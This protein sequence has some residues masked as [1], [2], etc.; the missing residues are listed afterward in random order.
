LVPFSASR[1]KIS[2]SNLK[3]LR[4]ERKEFLKNTISHG[5]IKKLFNL[6]EKQILEIPAVK[7]FDTVRYYKEDVIVALHAKK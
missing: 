7:K 5:Q 4:K 2:N 1:Q 6:S 3:Q